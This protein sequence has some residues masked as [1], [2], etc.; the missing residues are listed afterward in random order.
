M[1]GNAF[2][3][4]ATR[5]R[6]NPQVVKITTRGYA[7]RKGSEIPDRADDHSRGSGLFD[8]AIGIGQSGVATL[9]CTA[10]SKPIRRDETRHAFSISLED[11]GTVVPKL[12]RGKM[13]K[14][15][16]RICPDQQTLLGV[17]NHT[18]L[19]LREEKSL[20]SCSLS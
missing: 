14:A 19:D 16:W 4:Q 1:F 2:A 15:H 20:S 8:C 6:E 3:R 7:D 13:Q 10:R 9:D 11:L 18:E 12:N 17:T 5:K